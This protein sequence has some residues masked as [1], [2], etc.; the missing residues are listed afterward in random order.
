MAGGDCRLTGLFGLLADVRAGGL[1]GQ[2]DGESG[3]GEAVVCE[4]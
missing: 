2:T 3:E 4:V 1:A